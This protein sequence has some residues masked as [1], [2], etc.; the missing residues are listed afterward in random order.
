VANQFTTQLTD[1]IRDA[2]FGNMGS[3]IAFRIG[4]NDVEALTRYFQPLFDGDDLLRVPNWNAIV[5]TLVGGVPTQPFSMAGLPPLGTPNQQLADALK[6]LSGA[7]YGRPRAVVE[8]EIFARLATVDE[9]KPTSAGGFGARPAAGPAGLPSAAGA[10]PKPASSGSFLDDW[11]AKRQAP[12]TS[13]AGFGS[14][15]STGTAATTPPPTGAGSAYG[16]SQPFTGSPRPVSSPIAQNPYV[17]PSAPSGSPSTPAAATSTPAAATHGEISLNA[18]H[19]DED[20]L[21]NL[22]K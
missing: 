19:D 6:Q 7:K 18:N 16:S 12:T 15:P 9:P 3:I 10:P 14:R 1:E 5:R 22:D 17:A 20:H 8:K 2:I 4:Q 11:L 13:P 21:I